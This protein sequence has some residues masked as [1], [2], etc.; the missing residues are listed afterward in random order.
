MKKHNDTYQSIRD[1]RQYGPYW[2][3]VLW[4]IVRPVLVLAGS[5]L[6]VAG[7][8]S[9]IWNKVY[10]EYLAP[11]NAADHTQ[12]AFNVESGQSLTRVAHNLE[13]AGLIRNRTVFK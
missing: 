5:L 7:I 6:V 10:N 13:S 11:A 3:N 8:I 4:R 12:I 1:E 2:Y 9:G